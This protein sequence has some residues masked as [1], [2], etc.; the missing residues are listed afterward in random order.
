MRN[1]TALTTAVTSGAPEPTSRPT[2]DDL[3]FGKVAGPGSGGPGART[4]DV[5]MFDAAPSPSPA[6]GGASPRRRHGAGKPKLIRKASRARRAEKAPEREIRAGGMSLPLLITGALAAGIGL[7][8]GLTSEPEPGAANSLSLTMPDLPAPGLTPDDE[9][10]ATRRSAAAPTTTTRT[11]TAPTA[12]PT[13]SAPPSGPRTPARTSTPPP[14]STPTPPATR[15]PTP[16]P[17]QSSRRPGSSDSGLLS[18]GSSGPEVL[19]LQLRLQQL[20]LYL[21]SPDGT[22]G[23]ALEVALSRFQR[24]R[25]IPEEPGVYGPLTRAALYA[26]THRPDRRDRHDWNS[27]T[28]AGDRRD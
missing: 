1:R 10:S 8:V 20:Y 24:A 15:T 23:S 9:P 18:L 28:G 25:D 21:G 22:F 12:A 11:T 5:E 3:I 14:T 7:T 16:V 13:T 2:R 17:T 19:D 26:E 4:Q 6:P 27:W